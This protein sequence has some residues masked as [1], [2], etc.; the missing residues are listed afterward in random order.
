MWADLLV[1][2][3]DA[4]YMGTQ[5]DQPPTR[6][7]STRTPACQN[8]YSDPY[9][10]I[11]KRDGKT[12]VNANAIT[13]ASAVTGIYQVNWDDLSSTIIASASNG[14]V[15]KEATGVFSEIASGYYNG[16]EYYYSFVKLNNL[17]IW[18]NGY[19]TIKKWDGTTVSDLGGISTLFLR[20]LAVFK[21][22]L[23]CFRGSTQPY[24]GYFSGLGDPESWDLA[25][26]YLN[27]DTGD[28]D[29]V[30]NAV[31]HEDTIYVFKTRHVF[32]VFA[33]G[34]VP[35]FAFD[36]ISNTVG[37]PSGWAAQST[38]AGLFFLG[39]D[40]IYKVSGNE[41]TN[42]SASI[43][44]VFLGKSV[45]ELPGLNTSRLQYAQSGVEYS[46][47]Q[48]WVLCSTGPAQQHDYAWVLDWQSG[49]LFPYTIAANTLGRI[50]VSGRDKIY[51]GNY[52]GKI[53]KQDQ[54]TDDAGT[55]IDGWYI[56][57][58][59]DLDDPESVKRLLYLVIHSKEIG[60]YFLEVYWK[61]D[62]ARDWEGPAPVQMYG[63]DE[64]FVGLDFIM[65][66][67]EVGVQDAIRGVVPIN[68]RGR[69]IQ[70][71]FRNRGTEAV[72]I[73]KYTV[74]AQ[75]VSVHVEAVT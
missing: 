69:N 8:M 61:I 60:R 68:R 14:A 73:D 2:T 57:P 36:E 42:M 58:H 10:T 51:S 52:A 45:S 30:T 44:N 63:A 4:N 20:N 15:Y 21:R 18:T 25:D 31:E 26:D 6:V 1:K 64:A 23:W 9:G 28:G 24:L 74:L 53:Y 35:P 32:R 38:E 40:G 48:F 39:S 72:T 34:S 55:A 46:K 50:N 5:T 33:T 27:F 65:G 43:K 49:G 22:R 62:F 7:D 54:G 17:A 67:S 59:L 3:Y 13:G 29:V 70:F 47:K 71:K 66:T 12:V 37:S 19:D 56:T 41:I 75:N 16:P 11:R